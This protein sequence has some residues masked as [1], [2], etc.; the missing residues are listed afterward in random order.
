M[1]YCLYLRKSR[2]DLEAEAHGEG[3]TLARH[4]ATLMSLAVRRNIPIKT[5]YKEIVSG[6][7]ISARPIMQRLL[8]EVGS[9]EWD[10]VLVVE[11]E[12]LARGDTIDQGLVAQAFQA[13]GTKIITPSKTYDPR[14]EFDEEYF[15]FSLFMSRREYKTINRRIQAGRL[16]SVREGKYI[17]AE[18]PYGYRKE[19][20]ENQKGFILV[21]DENEAEYL[22]MIFQMYVNGKGIAAI[23]RRMEELCAPPRKSTRWG[24]TTIRRIISNPVYKGYTPWGITK[25]I[26][27]FNDGMKKKRVKAEGEHL[28]R[29]LHVPLVDEETWN[30]AQF[31]RAKKVL[32]HTPQSTVLKNPLSGLVYCSECGYAMVRHTPKP[33]RPEKDILTCDTRGCPTMSHRIDLIELEALDSLRRWVTDTEFVYTNT[34]TST[35]NID[36]EKN[37]LQKIRAELTKAK[38]QKESLYALLEQGIYS[39][40]VFMERSEALKKKVDGIEAE[41]NRL[42]TEID[43]ATNVYK[44][45]FELLPQVKRV[46][47]L[48]DEMGN[49]ERKN[50]L[51]KEVVER[52]T[53]SKSREDKRILLTL[54]VR[55]I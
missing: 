9:G 34:D 7:T 29:G 36:L 33:T 52:V 23:M 46:I 38:K 6:E 20:L 14:N 41:K 50:M 42:E 5:V 35:P 11:I 37:A 40:E 30:K 28:Y 4:E 51:L 44:R 22:K 17:A 13:S 31:I 53:Y 25:G 10:G 19:K 16:A 54:T 48:Y 27:D 49:A 2:A 45:H 26:K 18:A 32:P 43:A 15:E 12:R 1:P 8:S 3:E 55:V 21:V 24:M 39:A 47:D